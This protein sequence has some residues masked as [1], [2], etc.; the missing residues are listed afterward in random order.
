MDVEKQLAD[1]AEANS[2]VFIFFYADWC[3][4]YEWIREALETYEKRTVKYIQVN[5][6]ENEALAQSYNI[7]TVPTFVLMHHKYELWRKIS[8]ITVDE[9]R[10]VLSEF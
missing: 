8:D 4:H 7:G 10:L 3:P 5:V 1:L 9:L 6:E 2:L